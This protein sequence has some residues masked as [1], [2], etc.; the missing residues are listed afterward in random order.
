MKFA[1]EIKGISLVESLVALVVLAVGMLGIAALYVEGLRSGRTALMRSQA[2]I[3]ASDM[4]DRIRANPGGGMS[5][6]KPVDEDGAVDVACETGAGCTP[7]IMAAHD[8]ARWHQAI[9]SRVN[10]R[11]PTA[12]PGG[13]GAIAVDNTTDPFT[14]RITVTWAESNQAT[15]STYELRVQI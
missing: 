2:V 5:Y 4:S 15:L 3:L 13:R 11:S 1:N 8:I 6:A 10:P 7:D 14:Y 9:D 12:L